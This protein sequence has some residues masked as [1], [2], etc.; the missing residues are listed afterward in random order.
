MNEPKRFNIIMDITMSDE[1]YNQLLEWESNPAQWIKTI[2]KHFAQEDKGLTC[3]LDVVESDHPMLVRLSENR[4]IYMM[5]D[6][7]DDIEQE[8][9]DSN[10]YCVGGNCED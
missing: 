10:H 7:K 2:F 3:N 6:A 9:I 4:E 1:K 8:I 5:Q